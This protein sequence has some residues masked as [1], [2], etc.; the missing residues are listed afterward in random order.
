ME[1]HA[2]YCMRHLLFYSSYQTFITLA[3]GSHDPFLVFYKL[4]YHFLGYFAVCPLQT[5][6]RVVVTSQCVFVFAPRLVS[7]LPIAPAH[8]PRIP[9]SASTL[10]VFS[11]LVTGPFIPPHL[12]SVHVGTSLVSVRYFPRPPSVSLHS[13][14]FLSP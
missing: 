12:L 13:R 14:L 10:C 4:P 9:S 5:L 3:H 8:S 6:L 7:C 11:S 2:L 1:Y